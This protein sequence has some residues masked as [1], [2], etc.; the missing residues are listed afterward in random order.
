MTGCHDRVASLAFE[1]K[2]RGGPGNRTVLTAACGWTDTV[3][4]GV[5][6]AHDPAAARWAGHTCKD[7]ETNR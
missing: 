2:R 1:S 6:W 4:Q 3:V 7:E 5:E